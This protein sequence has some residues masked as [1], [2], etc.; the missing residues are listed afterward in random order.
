MCDGRAEQAGNSLRDAQLPSQMFP[1]MRRTS[2]PADSQGRFNAL[3]SLEAEAQRQHRVH[4]ERMQKL[5]QELL[6]DK[7]R[8]QQLDAEAAAEAASREQDLAA[9]VSLSATAAVQRLLLQLTGL[10]PASSCLRAC[11]GG[12]CTR[13]VV[14]LAR[15]QALQQSSVLTALQ[16]VH[17]GSE[18]PPARDF[19]SYS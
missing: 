11:C 3:Q 1:A 15:I 13:S 10:T 4:Q 19:P 9:R 18:Q 12:C 7:A 8:L 16:R 2:V 17:L 6:V 14:L 5:R